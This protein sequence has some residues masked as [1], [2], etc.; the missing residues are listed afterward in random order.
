[1]IT[2]YYKPVVYIHVNLKEGRMYSTMGT[3]NVLEGLSK[4]QRTLM[5]IRKHMWKFLFR[6]V[7]REN[8]S[9]AEEKAFRIVN[10]WRGA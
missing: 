1:M 9:T 7:C 3:C 8:R 5:W 10:R 4:K 2:E 6:R